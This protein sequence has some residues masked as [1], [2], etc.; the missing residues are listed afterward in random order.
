M[1]GE[2]GVGVIVGGIRIL[3]M[4]VF[5]VPFNNDFHFPLRATRGSLDEP[6]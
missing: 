2:S 5:M 6:P 1:G 3:G 4:S